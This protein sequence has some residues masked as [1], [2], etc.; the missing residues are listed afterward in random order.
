VLVEQRLNE[1]RW[2]TFA[3][4]IVD[5]DKWTDLFTR[6]KDRPPPSRQPFLILDITKVKSENLRQ[7]LFSEIFGL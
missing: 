2:F 4:N 3:G 7:A 5:P 1:I 6:I